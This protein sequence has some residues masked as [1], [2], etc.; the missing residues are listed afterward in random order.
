METGEVFRR[1][2]LFSE[3]LPKKNKRKK[4]LSEKYLTN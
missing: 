2:Y 1:Q 3:N 4:K